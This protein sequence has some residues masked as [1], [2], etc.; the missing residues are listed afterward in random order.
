M[1]LFHFRYNREVAASALRATGGALLA[2][3]LT[4]CAMSAVYAKCGFRGCPG[5]AA[6]SA[7]VRAL[8][9]RHPVLE[10][11]NLL[12]VRTLDHVVYLGGIVDTD[13]ERQIAASVASE[14]PGVARV[15][16]SIGLANGR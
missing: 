2:G 10:A 6:T 16:N 12:S 15:V 5:D 11:P 13:F 1:R 8:F 9:E 4:G 3:V 14:A 7:E